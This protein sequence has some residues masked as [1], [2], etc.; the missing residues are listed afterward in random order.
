MMAQ[1]TSQSSHTIENI[2]D[3]SAMAAW[4]QDSSAD[5][6]LVQLQTITP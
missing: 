6:G 2:F 1:A 5:T 3:C 4:F